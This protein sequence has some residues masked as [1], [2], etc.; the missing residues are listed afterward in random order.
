MLERPALADV[1]K[2]RRELVVGVSLLLDREDI[3]MV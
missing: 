3:V 1:R 2:R